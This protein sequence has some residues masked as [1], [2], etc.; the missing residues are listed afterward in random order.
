MGSTTTGGVDVCR[1]CCVLAGRGI[2]DGLIIRSEESYRLWCV[3]VCDLEI[4]SMRGPWSNKGCWAERKKKRTLFGNEQKSQ[5]E[6]A[7]G[8]NAELSLASRNPTV[9]LQNNL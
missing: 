7:V 3:V 8:S 1:E 5:D 4:S 9:L 6:T 2:S